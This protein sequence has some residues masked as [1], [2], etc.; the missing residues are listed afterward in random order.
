MKLFIVTA[1][2]E[3]SDQATDIFKKAGI[4]VLSATDIS[5]FKQSTSHNLLDDWFGAGDARFDSILFFSFTMEDKA[6]IALKL[7]QA[8]NQNQGGEFP[9]RAFILPVEK[10]SH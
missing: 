10:F 9:L 6:D 5:G 2:K 1:L 8:Y 3:Y 4:H 7:I